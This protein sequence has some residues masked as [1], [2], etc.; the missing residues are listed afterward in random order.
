MS[1]ELPRAERG[2]AE[3]MATLDAEPAS[4]SKG[5][6]DGGWRAAGSRKMRSCRRCVTGFW[7]SSGDCDGLRPSER[8][9]DGNALTVGARL[10]SAPGA[11]AN[12]DEEVS[13]IE[14]DTS[15]RRE[16]ERQ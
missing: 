12:D 2:V 1:A 9:I 13:A 10:K 16:G 8:D 7:S 15:A 4:G 14:A 3:E 6:D 11:T 5:L